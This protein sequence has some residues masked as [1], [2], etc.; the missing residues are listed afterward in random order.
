MKLL[1]VG[2]IFGHAGRRIVADH[3]KDIRKAQ[4]I[5]DN[6]L[7]R[8]RIRPLPAG[9]RG[10]SVPAAQPDFERVVRRIAQVETSA[11]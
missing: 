5:D 11:V 9:D 10:G 4:G 7:R 3:V 2:D 8:R 6:N 1:F